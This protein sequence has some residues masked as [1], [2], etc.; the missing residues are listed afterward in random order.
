M[1][2]RSCSAHLSPIPSFMRGRASRS[3]LR[4]R[5]SRED[6]LPSLAD[7]RAGPGTGRRRRSERARVP[8]AVLAR[9][10]APETGPLFSAGMCSLGAARAVSGG[11]RLRDAQSGTCDPPG[12][13]KG[14][15]EPGTMTRPSAEAGACALRAPRFRQGWVRAARPG[16]T[17]LAC[18][19][20][21][22]AQT[23]DGQRYAERI[24]TGSVDHPRISGRAER[25]M[26]A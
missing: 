26:Y 14:R 15:G 5:G 20:A 19:F 4:R 25:R 17:V 9:V 24:R 8:A 7:G 16:S 2:S 23:C 21:G 12:R 11:G 13:G 18:A 3:S 1:G 22:A 10:D 6:A